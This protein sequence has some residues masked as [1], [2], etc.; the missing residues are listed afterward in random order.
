MSLLG[1]LADLGKLWDHY[2]QLVLAKGTQFEMIDIGLRLVCTGYRI[3]RPDEVVWAGWD[4]E[5]RLSSYIGEGVVGNRLADGFQTKMAQMR[6]VTTD[7]NP[8][9]LRQTL[10]YL[11][12]GFCRHRV[13]GSSADCHKE[14]QERMIQP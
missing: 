7:L 4:D 9:L 2:K 10:S 11:E 14:N 3:F 5:Y 6:M 12:S 8:Q 1:V 13:R